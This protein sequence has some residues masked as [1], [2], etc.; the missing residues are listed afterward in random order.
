VPHPAPRPLLRL[1]AAAATAVAVVAPGS[2]AP[3]VAAPGGRHPV[4]RVLVLSLPGTTWE[5]LHDARTPNLDRLLAGSAVASGSLRA[6][7]RATTPGEGYATIGAGTPVSGVNRLDNLAFQADESFEGGQAADVY[8]RRTGRPASGAVLSLAG[9]ALA[10]DAKS[11]HRGAEIGALGQAL[12]RAGVRRA[13]VANA[14]HPVS[15]M[16]NP[17]LHREAALA[18]IDAGGAVEAGEVDRALLR[19]DPSAPYRVELDPG[20]AGD[21]LRRAW[22]APRAVV[23]VEAS[24]LARAHTLRPVIGEAQWRAL[25][26]RQLERTDALLGPILDSVDIRRDAVMVVAPS[27]P[28]DAIHLTVAA[29]SAPGVGKGVL[30]SGSTRRPGFVTLFDYA[31]TVLDL[32]GLPRPASMDGRP[33]EVRAVKG[34]IFP[35]IG[36]LVEADR[37]AVFRD[38]MVGPVAGSFV[39]GQLL[40]SLVAAVVLARRRLTSTIRRRISLA[41]LW[42]LAVLPLTSLP[43]VLDV[44]NRAVYAG[45]VAGGAGVVAAGIFRLAGGTRDGLRPVG[46]ILGIIF[47]VVVLDVVSGAHLQL[48]TVFG[49]SPTVGGRFAGL[50]NLA[51]AELAA[52]AALLAGI[53]AH[54]AGG[55]RG[56]VAAVVLLAVAILADG[57][58]IWGSDVGGV[59]SAVPAFAVVALGIAGIRLSWARVAALAGAAVAAVLAFGGL[60]LLR[61]APERTH[62]GRLLERM[63]TDGFSAFSDVV[64]RKLDENLAVLPTSIWVPV[65]PAVLAFLAWLAWGGAS[66]LEVMRARA[67]ELRPALAGVLVV[68]VLGFALNDSGIAVPAMVLG[69]LNPVLVFLALEWP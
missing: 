39:V 28:G 65:V 36:R 15:D 33:F 47:A 26:R 7:N 50:G 37:E 41:A 3:A 43:A 63:G 6:I 44:T 52:S 5:A 11:R 53:V 25:V 58:P 22:A 1:A 14:D 32:L 61:P 2:A 60:D 18:L 40:L 38:R 16:G 24:D 56:L 31:P 64:Q 30:V 49:Y 55:R 45:L 19:P 42:L 17:E 13:V 57:M 21:A 48:S 59:L 12:A 8:T 68:G 66:R 20:A 29:L 34:G 69:V 67:P 4:D 35:P 51:F 62:L 10:A 9:P 27:D 46:A 23:L 54:F